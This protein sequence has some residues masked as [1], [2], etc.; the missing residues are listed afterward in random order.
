MNKTAGSS[1][2]KKA[3]ESIVIFDPS[4]ISPNLGDGIIA[5]SVDS[6]LE[7]LFPF[8]YKFHIPTHDYIGKISKEIIKKHPLKFIAGS[9]L[10]SSNMNS[11]NQWKVKLKD[12]LYLKN[13]ILLGVG[14]WKYQTIPNLYT[15]LLYKA[16]L[17]KNH[18]H[19]VRDI[20]TEKHLN[21][22]GFNNV[23]YTGCPTMWALT[24]EHCSKIKIHKSNK[25]I[26]TLTDYTKAWIKDKTMIDII[27]ENYDE[28]FFW[29][30]GA[31]DLTYYFELTGEKDG[32]KKIKILPLNLHS[33]IAIL[34]KG[35][36]DYIGTR[37]HSGI[38]ALNKG[39]RTIIVSISNRTM[40]IHKSTKLP[41]VKR[42]NIKDLGKLIHEDIITK[43]ELPADNIEKWTNQF[44]D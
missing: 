10:L 39:I 7:R 20:Y 40:E 28:V 44:N 26:F 35:D 27:I 2:Q 32:Y 8:A 11:Y 18:L 37:L 9:N 16:I 14:W 21:A 38:L 24:E 30:Q 15:K 23:L 4:L 19:S 25:A 13:V 1:P 5:D 6:T 12:S 22:I 3:I 43:I 29:P 31:H 33:F 42:N 36:I 41:I 17:S 34:E